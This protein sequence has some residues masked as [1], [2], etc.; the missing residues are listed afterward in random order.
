M[1]D[2][3]HICGPVR[4]EA[5]TELCAPCAL[6]FEQRARLRSVVKD[7]C[8]DVLELDLDEVTDRQIEMICDRAAEKM[9]PR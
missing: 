7:A 8:K 2:R 3:C 9:F 5:P 4:H 6:V 1:S